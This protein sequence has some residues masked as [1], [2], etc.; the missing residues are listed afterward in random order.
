MIKLCVLKYDIYIIYF[1]KTCFFFQLFDIV[2]QIIPTGWVLSTGYWVYYSNQQ[3]HSLCVCSRFAI[4]CRHVRNYDHW[5]D[6]SSTTDHV[7]DI[8]AV[9][10]PSNASVTASVSTLYT[11]SLN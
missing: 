8:T 2:N 4:P 11:V 6:L 3:G 1:T 9:T 5:I 7:P 10:L